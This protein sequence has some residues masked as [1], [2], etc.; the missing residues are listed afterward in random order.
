MANKGTKAVGIPHR[1]L[2]T[3]FPINLAG[4]FFVA[5]WVPGVSQPEIHPSDL[6][7]GGVFSG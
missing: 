2:Q 4:E 6:I 3:C 5:S 1:N 7:D